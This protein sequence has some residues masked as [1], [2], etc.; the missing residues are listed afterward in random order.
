ML[1]INRMNKRNAAC[2][3]GTESR[4]SLNV[5]NEFFETP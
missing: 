3:E 2:H 5:S 4:C 1:D